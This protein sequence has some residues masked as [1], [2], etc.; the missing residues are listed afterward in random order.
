MT[1]TD[2]RET[3]RDTAQNM[4]PGGFDTDTGFGLIR[5]DAAL[6][7]LH[8]FGITAGPTGTP[9]PVVPGGDVSRHH[10]QRQTATR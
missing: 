8:E 7:A 10:R 1:P 6:N 4:G 5:A 9:N 3:L 2:V